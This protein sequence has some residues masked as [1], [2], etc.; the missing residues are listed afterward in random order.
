MDTKME[1][2]KSFVGIALSAGLAL[3]TQDKKGIAIQLVNSVAGNLMSSFIEKA[4]YSKLQNLLKETDPA[5][6]NH[7]LNKLISKAI[8]WA[9][10]NIDYLYRQN[11]IEEKLIEQTSSFTK[12]LLLEVKLLDALLADE[13]DGIFEKIER[14]KS[15]EEVFNL[16][17]IK[18]QDFPTINP[19]DPFPAFFR[20][21]FIPNLQLCFGELLKKKSNRPAYIAYQRATYQKL[22]FRI[23]QIIQ[24]NEEVINKLNKAESSNVI[25]QNSKDWQKINNYFQK[26]DL[27]QI[28]PEFESIFEDSL[29][30]LNKQT[31][32]LVDFTGEIKEEVLKVKRIAKNFNKQLRQNWFQK[33]KVIVLGLFTFTFVIICFLVLKLLSAPFNT[34]IGIEV[35]PAIQVQDAYP[36]LSDKAKLRF[37]LPNGMKEKGISFSNEISL[38]NL[39]KSLEG[40]LCKVELIDRYWKLTDDSLK[41]SKGSTRIFLQPNEALSVISG[42]VLSRNGQELIEGVKVASGKNSSFTDE[43]GQF[44]IKVPIQERKLKHVLRVEK[45][46]FISKEV[47][48]NAGAPVE[49]RLLPKE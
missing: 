16:L 19:S 44:L 6:L 2:G 42:R 49:I 43:S 26:K 11:L 35:N 5:D 20:R 17:D 3:A 46:D 39:S 29:S 4:E 34:N 14:P 37:F 10:R 47:E 9:I 38:S 8:E 48:Y 7:D 22:D 23:S 12:E 24:Q 13:D 36:K 25:I 41:I 15:E 28:T 33:N 31:S 21:E 27:R 32:L 30:V 18:I 45:E 1:I 40:E